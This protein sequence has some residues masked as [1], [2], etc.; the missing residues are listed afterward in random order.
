M[1]RI[2]PTD[3]HHADARTAAT[4]QA[5]ETKLG[6]LPNLL[7][8]L[9]RA[10]AALNGYLQ[11]SEAL[12]QGRLSAPQRELIALAVAQENACA[13]CLSAHTALAQGTGLSEAAIARAR[14]HG[15]SDTPDE[16]LIEL[17]RRIVRSRAKLDDGTLEAARRAGLDDGLIIETIAQVA[18]NLLTNYVNH[19][20]GTEVDFPV[21][22]LRPAA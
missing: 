17:S 21:V 18:L 12:G 15:A 8:T 1:P 14:R 19:V 4:L 9:A 6:M 2:L 20:A 13:Y 10:P 22:G 5:V 11:F 7:A 16:A 3:P